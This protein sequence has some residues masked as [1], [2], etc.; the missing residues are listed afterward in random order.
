[1]KQVKLRAVEEKDL[2]FLHELRQD[3][4]IQKNLKFYWPISMANQIKWFNK[5]T[6][7]KENKLLIIEAIDREYEQPAIQHIT[8]KAIGNARI[9]HI[10]HFNKT[11]EIGLDICE[12]FRGKGLGSL[13]FKEIMNFCFENLAMRKLY[14]Y[15]FYFNKAGMAVYKKHGFKIEGKLKKHLFKNGKYEDLIL[16]SKFR[17]SN[18]R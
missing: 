16:M 1:M 18:L 2:K 9:Q 5:L 13:A 15:V 12:D 17:Q 11:A 4:L 6:D 8:W 3:T 14:L 10:D 7:S